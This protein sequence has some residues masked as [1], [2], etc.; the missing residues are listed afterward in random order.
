MRQGWQAIFPLSPRL[1]LVPLLAQTTSGDPG[2]S[3]IYVAMPTSDPF[4]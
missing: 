2:S 4:R 3:M 1:A